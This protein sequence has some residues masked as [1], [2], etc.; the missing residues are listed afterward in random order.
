[1]PRLILI[2]V[3]AG[4]L[5]TSQSTEKANARDGGLEGPT[6][7]KGQQRVP[8]DPPP[9]D[10]KV[11]QSPRC[12][13]GSAG[14]MCN[15]SEASKPGG[16]SLS[17]DQLAA[18]RKEQEQQKEFHDR[19]DW[20]LSTRFMR[21]VLDRFRRETIDREIPRRYQDLIRRMYEEA[22]REN[23]H[24]IQRGDNPKPANTGTSTNT[25]TSTDTRTSPSPLISYLGPVSGGGKI[26]IGGVG[27]CGSSQSG[28]T[29]LA[30][31]DS[32][33]DPGQTQKISKPNFMAASRMPDFSG[34]SAPAP[35]QGS[36]S[37]SGSTTSHV[38]LPGGYF[39]K[40]TVN[41]DGTVTVSNNLGTVTLSRDQLNKVAAGDLGP[42]AALMGGAGGAGN[43][44]K[45]T[46]SSSSS[47]SA[48]R[49]GS[50]SI[51]GL[52]S[53]SSSKLASVSS[54]NGIKIDPA[55]LRTKSAAASTPMVSSLG[56]PVSGNSVKIDLG[57][58][59]T[60]N[61][62]ASGA[63]TISGAS[64]SSPLSSGSRAVSIENKPASSSTVTGT[65]AA[66]SPA[67]PAGSRAISI[68]NKPAASS[69]ITINTPNPSG[70]VVASP[71]PNAAGGAASGAA[72]GAANRAA[73]GA[74][75]RAASTV[76]STSA[77]NAAGHAASG[78]A[79]RAA[80]N[81]AS[82]AASNAASNAA[83]RAASNA[84]SNAASR[85][86]SNAA[87]N[88]AANAASR[89]RIPSD[90]RLKRDIVE[91]GQLSSGLH[92]YRYRYIGD[93]E[94]YVGVMAQEVRQ[95]DPGAIGHGADGYLSVDY[96]RLGLRFMTWDQ[97]TGNSI[98]K[99]K[100]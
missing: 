76:A 59:G 6:N 80:S 65:S 72:S 87:S 49:S 34:A 33:P 85:A 32:L 22:G 17:W 37:S 93:R 47:S 67:S 77:S 11:P 60:A 88:A 26:C 21:S 98:Q 75:S 29:G 94:Y 83:S 52:G 70:R 24:R 41:S 45:L 9:Q 92:V 1:V 31:A 2:A 61:R 66:I 78:A 3:L 12:A 43:S 30:A 90:V 53:S 27:E 44:G 96:D 71:A 13:S 97:W 25:N 18:K 35:G 38:N 23:A 99:A 64:S 8:V 95:V 55:L 7:S 82:R 10:A 86:A 73:S 51:S 100:L 84:A 39:G 54:G 81:A 46:G 74:A 15:L 5:A 36:G 14:T 89:I 19:T 56:G 63:S 42:V 58:A 40:A 28:I 62:A 57:S 50:S 16:G 69:T 68:A 48:S 20:K 79:G 91:V 4:L